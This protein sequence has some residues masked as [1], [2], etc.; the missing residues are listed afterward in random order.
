MRVP[1]FLSQQT[2]TDIP[3]YR[4]AFGIK[5][6]K[7]TRSSTL[8]HPVYTSCPCL[9]S[10]FSVCV[11]VY[12]TLMSDTCTFPSFLF[13]SFALYLSFSLLERHVSHLFRRELSQKERGNC[14]HS[15][16][17]SPGLSLTLAHLEGRGRGRERSKITTR[18]FAHNRQL[19]ML[20][21]L[22]IRSSMCMSLSVC[23]CVYVCM[24]VGGR[25]IS[26]VIL[27]QRIAR[28]GNTVRE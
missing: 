14:T 20:L 27:T 16:F 19:L 25:D 24:C 18:H 22:S 28:I 12:V 3:T 26:Y 15:L 4:Q 9:F 23:V 11:C 17:V 1:F 8:R 21:S 5:R 13:F 6:E 2:L 10:L 7:E